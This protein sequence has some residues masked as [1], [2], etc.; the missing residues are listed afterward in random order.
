MKDKEEKARHIANKLHEHGFTAYYAGGSVR[1]LFLEGKESEDYDIATDAKPDQIQSLFDKTLEVGKQF[2]VI[3][4]VSDGE[5][6]EVATFRSEAD[7]SDG[8]RPDS[9]SFTS[10]KEDAKRRDFTI[11]GMFYDPI[12]E[13]VIDYVDGQEDIEK[14]LIRAIGDPYERFDED[15]LRMLRAVRFYAQL[16]F[17]IEER[18]LNAVKELAH[19]IK[20]VSMERIR[21]EFTKGLT[22]SIPHK[23]VDMCSETGL[24]ENFIP[25]VEEMKGVP[26]PPQFHPEGDVYEHTLLALKELPE[27]SS[28]TLVYATLLHDIGKPDT[29]SVE[30]RI[31]FDKHDTV[32]ARKAEAVLE[33]L[34]FS[35]KKIDRIT[36]I[37]KEHMRFLH[38]REMRESTLKKFM[39][40][41]YFEELLELHKADCLASHKDLSEYKFCKNKLRKFQ[42]ESL[43]EA[44]RP[45]P[46][47]DGNDLLNLGLPEGPLIGELLEK[48]ENAQLEGKLNTKEE[49]LS[50]VK[51]ILQDKE[52]TYNNDN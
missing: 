42:R 11:N 50:Y 21:E 30:E 48:V 45:E 29:F 27:E 47:I 28:E 31:R 4:V 20:A 51:N 19:Q 18:T 44:L 37:I 9:V 3:I 22:S 26:Q 15:K 12:S 43:Q 52:I 14:E 41:D 8:R 38:C 2:G 23:F 49:A 46:L 39:R 33:R 6:F 1:D 5:Q 36:A 25:E 13:E 10:P 40:S 7:Y 17:D 24:L 35:N 32:S 34:K 16:Q